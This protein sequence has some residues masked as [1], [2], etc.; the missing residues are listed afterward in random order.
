[1]LIDINHLYHNNLGNY[2]LR[3]SEHCGRFLS[4]LR[5]KVLNKTD[6]NLN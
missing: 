5:C 6:L 1:M 3:K 2:G 4:H